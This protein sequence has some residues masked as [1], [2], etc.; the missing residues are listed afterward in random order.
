MNWQDEIDD[1]DNSGYITAEFD[2]PENAIP[3]HYNFKVC[4]QDSTVDILLG[5]NCAFFQRA[6]YGDQSVS[7]DMSYGN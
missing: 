6:Y 7:I 5:A 4:A 2:I 1:N 3:I